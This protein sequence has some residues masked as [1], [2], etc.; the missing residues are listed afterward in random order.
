MT[1]HPI[2]GKLQ[3]KPS[4][5]SN[6][7]YNDRSKKDARSF[8]VEGQLKP[9]YPPSSTPEKKVFKCPS[10][11]KN[12]WLSQ[13]SD[14]KELRLRDR[15]KFVHA[16]KLCLNCLVSG[17][18]VQDCPKRSFCRVERCTKKHS[19]FLHEKERS[20]TATLLPTVN[21]IY[22]LDLSLNQFEST[23]WSSNHLSSRTS[24]PCNSFRFE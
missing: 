20:A 6:L 3:G 23:K 7:K 19:T 13:C 22:G 15:L 21:L 14:F 10:C 12:H 8:A 2:F 1:N 5:S 11:N 9:P 18:F 16:K 24:L 17:H 4:R